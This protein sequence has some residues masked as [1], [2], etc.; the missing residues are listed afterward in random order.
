MAED[1]IFKYK[2]KTI[3]ELKAL[4]LEEFALLVPSTLR[5]KI[6]RGFSEQEQIL[7]EKINDGE[8]NIKTHSRDMI[9]LP[10]MVGLKLGI[11]NGKEFVE[12]FI[13][14][15]MVGMRFGELAMTRKIAKHTTMGAKR[16]VVRK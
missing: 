5:R 6:N 1:K 3:E 8:K 15:E 11:H 13:V 12:V 14:V 7:M 4:S 2:G 16:T 10:N 9:V